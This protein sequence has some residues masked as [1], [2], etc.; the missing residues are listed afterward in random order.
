MTQAESLD[1]RNPLEPFVLDDHRLL[2]GDLV[3]DLA[4]RTIHSRS[5]R[6]VKLSGNEFVILALLTKSPGRFVSKEELLAAVAGPETD[7][8]H[9]IVDTYITYL[10]RLLQEADSS[11]TIEKAT[12]LGFRLVF[13]RVEYTNA[14]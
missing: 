5:M 13:E 9:S 6:S 14:G 7:P 10:H 12:G 1:T 4:L 2:V 11:A 8:H 3:L